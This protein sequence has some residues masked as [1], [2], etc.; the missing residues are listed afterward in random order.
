MQHPIPE[1]AARVVSEVTSTRDVQRFSAKQLRLL[2]VKKVISL[3]LHHAGVHAH[4]VDSF[5]VKI[6]VKE[7]GKTTFLT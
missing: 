4:N 7:T 6:P 3:V 2:G 5:P 1:D